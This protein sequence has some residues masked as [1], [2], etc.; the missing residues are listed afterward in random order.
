M[1][2]TIIVSLALAMG[3]GR[4]IV[5]FQI[6]EI[7]G[8][9]KNYR[10][11]PHVMFSASMFKPDADPRSGGEFAFENFNF[12]ASELA[13]DS[14]NYA[15]K[16]V[17]GV[18]Y[19]MTQAAIQSIGF[20]MNLRTLSSSLFHGLNKIFDIFVR[21][22]NL[23]IHEFHKTFLLQ[24]SAMEKSGAIATGAIYAGISM[25]RSIMNFFQLMMNISI[26]ILV[27]LVVMVIFLF[28]LLAPTI[29]LILTTIAI[30]GAS[31][32]GGAVAGM[33]EAF[34][35]S[36]ETLIILFD[37]SSKPIRLIRNG[38]VL[39]DGSLVKSTM[40][41]LTDSGQH[42]YNLDGIIVSGSHIVYDKNGRPEFV[43]DS[44][45]IA[46]SRAP[47]PI[48]YC[49][50]T[51]THKIPVQGA[52]GIVM[53]A[54][55]EELDSDDM[56]EWD[57][58]VRQKLGSLPGIPRPGLCESETGFYPYVKLRVRLAD[59]TEDMREIGHINL[60]DMVA[61]VGGWTQVVG[62]VKID[63]SEALVVGPM[64]SGANWVLRE[65]GWERI[66]ENPKW[67]TGSP[68]SQLVS[69]FTKSGTFIVRETLVRDFSDIGLSS[70]E[71]SY[72]FTLSRLIENTCSR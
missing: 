16:P 71:D 20:T 61:D 67:Q 49:L 53:F 30:I 37:G 3:L 66:G 60:G 59:G 57:A 6:K 68:V 11:M 10:C 54:D 31:A 14:L 21:R 7:L 69:L 15:L 72:G 18:F 63:G 65:R 32:A 34:C 27:I 24:L 2:V 45:A 70:I 1:W 28:F 40:Q 42:F 36:P 35:F 44:R 22:F 58:L 52:S 13:K 29:P 17:L 12:C 62:H 5:G 9:W 23:T 26:A 39:K 56:L 47:P 25:I 51:S 46:S 8:N 48:V 33:G 64:G 41:F 55:W 43:K 19:T 38:D 4:L 50:N